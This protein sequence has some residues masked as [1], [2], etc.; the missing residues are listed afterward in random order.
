M[1][2]YTTM[3]QHFLGTLQ[4]PMAIYMF[5]LLFTNAQPQR[6]LM[7][8]ASPCKAL[9]QSENLGN[10]V[11]FEFQFKGSKFGHWKVKGGRDAFAFRHLSL[12]QTDVHH[13]LESK[14]HHH[15]NKSGGYW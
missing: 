1:P 4:L 6:R 14:V 2:T 12:G 3:V 11:E 5:G 7:K 15:K 13:L 10:Q 8:L 9:A